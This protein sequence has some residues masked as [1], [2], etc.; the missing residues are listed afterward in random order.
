MKSTIVKR[1]GGVVALLAVVSLGL[2]AARAEQVLP[3]ACKMPVHVKCNV[4][5]SGCYNHPGPQITLDGAITLGGLGANLI[6]ENNLKGTH[7]APVETWATNIA[8]VPLGS[9]IVIPKQ[10]VNSG[11]GGNPHIYIQ[12][13]DGKCNALTEE[14]YL[15]RCVQGLSL[16]GDFLNDVIGATTIDTDGCNNHPGPVIT[17]GGQIVL[18]GLKARFIFRNNDKGTQTAQDY[19]DVNLIIE[20]TPVTLP[21]SPHLGGAGGNPLILLQFLQCD[22]T[23]IGDL[24]LL[25]RCNKL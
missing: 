2:T 6:F 10:P 17:M 14:L 9:C 1:A 24:F 12:F 19:R 8:L 7:S 20:G 22:E 5:E 25:G 3:V 13:L 21:K 18:S 16:E 15:G 11:V 23:P 4:N